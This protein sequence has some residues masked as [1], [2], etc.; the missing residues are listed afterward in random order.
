MSV[1]SRVIGFTLVTFVLG[2]QQAL[3]FTIPPINMPYGVTPISHEV[4]RLHM[5]TFYICA[6]IGVVVFGVLIYSLFKYRR[7]RG[8]VAAKFHEH[9]GIEILWTVIPFIILVAMAIPAT[10]VLMEIHNTAKPALDIKVIGYQWK[11]KYEYLDQGISFFSNLSTPNDQIYG[12]AKKNKWFLLEVD[13]PLVVPVN[14][15]IRI[16]VTSN[17]VIHSWWVPDLGMKQD[18]I[19]GYINENWFT[20]EKP[21]TYRGQC[22]ELCGANHAFMPIVVE[23]VTPAQFAAWVKQQHKLSGASQ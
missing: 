13:H 15:K 1:L 6:G 23:A 5:I 10:K 17:D 22:A 19:P 16:L 21:G 20:I 2:L 11:W 9:T 7:A 14:E 8:A 12:N 3:G 18:A 4:Y